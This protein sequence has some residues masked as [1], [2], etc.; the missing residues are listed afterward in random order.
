VQVLNANASSADLE[1]LVPT[2]VDASENFKAELEYGLSGAYGRRLSSPSLSTVTNPANFFNLQSGTVVV[3]FHLANLAPGTVYHARLDA[4]DIDGVLTGHD[5]AFVTSTLAQP[6]STG[7]LNLSTGTAT[8]N[9]PCQSTSACQGSVTLY[10]G[11]PPASLRKMLA[12]VSRARSVKL[13]TA[14][15]TIPAHH[16]TRIHIRLDA[17]GKRLARGH[18]SLVVTEVI[19]T[20]AHGHVATITHRLTLRTRH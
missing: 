4:S 15:F 14:R 12:R 13:G 18:K 19:T 9:L 3:T 11:Q 5:V 20:F 2:P 7:G 1:W 17:I 6:P 8:V 16:R 10:S